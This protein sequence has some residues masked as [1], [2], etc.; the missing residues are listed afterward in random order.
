MGHA[1]HLPVIVCRAGFHWDLEEPRGRRLGVLFAK[2]LPGGS[3]A[4]IL[5]GPWATTP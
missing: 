3:P 2:K 4:G 5:Q 1:F